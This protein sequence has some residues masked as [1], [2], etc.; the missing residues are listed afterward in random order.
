MMFFA[1]DTEQTVLPSELNPVVEEG[2]FHVLIDAGLTDTMKLELFIVDRR[3]IMIRLEN[4]GD[5]F[6]SQGM[7]LTPTVNLV[8]VIEGLWDTANRSSGE[9]QYGYEAVEVSLTGNEQYSTMAAKKIAWA[10]VDD[11]VETTPIATLDLES[12]EL[13][14]QRIRVFLV[15][16]LLL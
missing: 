7:V 5:I 4:I 1:W 14:Q 9:Q 3:T 11:T 13:Q 15:T 12:V 16:Y 8:T 10:T 2:L 6:N